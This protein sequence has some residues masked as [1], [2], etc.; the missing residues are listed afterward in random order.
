MF[1]YDKRLLFF[2][3]RPNNEKKEKL[4]RSL[5]IFKKSL[6]ES[7]KTK[8]YIFKKNERNTFSEYK[9]LTKE[10]QIE[11]WLIENFRPQ[12]KLKVENLGKNLIA[13]FII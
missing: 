4:F 9:I 6:F 1:Y 8:N 11:T 3:D 7:K 13:F 5:L 12:K 10:K 2:D